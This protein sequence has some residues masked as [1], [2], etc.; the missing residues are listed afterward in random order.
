MYLLYSPPQ[1][2]YALGEILQIN[3]KMPVIG[4]PIILQKDNRP[5]ACCFRIFYQRV[6]LRLIGACRKEIRFAH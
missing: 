2:F 3:I 1:A 5:E 6:Y 4:Q